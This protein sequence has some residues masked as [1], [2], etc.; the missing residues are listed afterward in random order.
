MPLLGIGRDK[1]RLPKLA[2]LRRSP[3]LRYLV[4]VVMG[5]AIDFGLAIAAFK[6]FDVPL[7]PAAV[8][9]FTLALT[10]N[11]LAL[12]FWA[13]GSRAISTGYL[14]RF[15][16]YVGASLF[17]LLF[18]AAAIFLLEPFAWS[19]LSRIAVLVIA[20]G[21]SLVVNYILVR[22]GVFRGRTTGS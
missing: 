3:E 12:E 21:A 14:L 2:E 13:F 9:G 5:Y 11:Y 6:I 20:A 1:P 4:V 8:I 18:R 22:F 7:L 16:K 19:D 10:A 17:T 15:G